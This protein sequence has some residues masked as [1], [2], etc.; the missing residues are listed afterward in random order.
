MKKTVVLIVTVLFLTMLS[1]SVSAQEKGVPSDFASDPA[2]YVH[3]VSGSDDSEAWQKWQSVHDEDF[4]EEKP[5][6]KYFYLP[7]SAEKS[8]AD[9]YNGYDEEVMLNG[10]KILS[11]TTEAV[12]YEAGLSYSV[13]VGTESYTLT[14]MNSNAEAAIYINNPD[15]DGSGLDLMS[16]LNVDK[17]RSAAASGAIVTPDGRIDNT[18][19]KK[20]KGRGNT[21]WGK[22]KKGYSITYDKDVGV[23]GMDP[24]KKYAITA[25]YQDDSLSRNRILYDLSDAVGLPYAPDSRYVDFYVNGFY[26]GSY[27]L[28]EKI[29]SG[30]LLPKIK[31][32]DYL[33]DDNTIKEDFDFVV[34]VNPSARDEDYWFSSNGM[35]ITIIS[36][37]IDPGDP[38]YEEVR[39]NIKE[40]FDQFY[41]A[42]SSSGDLS[43][44][45][46]IESLARLYLVNELGKNWD[47]G[48]ASTFFTYMQDENDVYRFYGSPVWD[49]DNSMGN[50][51]GVL[52]DLLSTGV[53]DYEQYTGWW[54]QHKGKL[55]SEDQESDNIIARISQNPEIKS[56]VP[57]I[58]FEDF[59]PALQHFAGKQYDAQIETELKTR[60][61]YFDLIQDSAKMNYTSGWL[62]CTSPWIAD[63][64]S[65][66][67]AVYDESTQ[68]MITDISVTNYEQNFEDM[69]NYAADW[70]LSRAAWLSEQFAAAMESGNPGDCPRHSTCPLTQFTDTDPQ[71]WYHD[72]VHWALQKKVMNGT[73][74]KTFEPMSS[75]TRAMI[76][77]M[78]WRM[79]GSPLVNDQMSF[80]DVP[81]GMWHTEAIR[82]AAAEGIVTGY[83]EDT[84][85]TPDD[86]TREQIVTILCRYAQFKGE[87]VSK[88]EST[89]LNHYTDSKDISEW[90]DKAFHWAVDAGIIQGMNENTLSPKTEAVRAQVAA[91]LMRFDNR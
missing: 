89:S 7:S 37:E 75:T 74:G 79:E 4:L 47:S 53:T 17:S 43:E 16:Y 20:I 46:D 58:W 70:M 39:E 44:A 61:E 36:P 80:K 14:M 73:G 54:C 25:N 83:N 45:A 1:M 3:A 77:T 34:E 30:G 55:S 38:G 59:L 85:G 84:F 11:H 64:S 52:D 26:W 71:A 60:D 57:A 12:P 9:V 35:K 87:D 66:N 29:D 6:E 90:A 32:A 18:E 10:V 82:W 63:H 24:I 49:Y 48:A 40:K 65:L 22:P 31:K 19:I 68:K 2:L 21:S 28:S 42:T 51:T 56:A 8:S 13:A 86:V 50:A 27:L 67:K 78:L 62:L 88:G 91:M 5:D 72:G 81:D 15:A 41:A 69:F 76:V 23:A 33:N